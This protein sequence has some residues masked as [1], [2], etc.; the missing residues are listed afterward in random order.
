VND[1]VVPISH[2]ERNA[3]YL[4]AATVRELEDGGH[5]FGN[6]LTV[7][8]RDIRALVQGAPTSDRDPRGRLREEAAT[9][10]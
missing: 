9:G 5:Q 10:E 4:P 1:E 3:A 2:L 8:A 7:V 6:D